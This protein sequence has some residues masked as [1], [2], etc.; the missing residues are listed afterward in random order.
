LPIGKVNRKVAWE[1][2]HVALAAGLIPASRAKGDAS[3]KSI[4]P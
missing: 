2:Q 4:I 3:M 1:S